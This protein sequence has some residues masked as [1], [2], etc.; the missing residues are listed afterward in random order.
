MG[1]VDPASLYRRRWKSVKLLTGYAELNKPSAH[2]QMPISQSIVLGR[3]LPGV[4]SEMV[5]FGPRQ[6]HPRR[7]L[8][9]AKICRLWMDT[10]LH[11]AAQVLNPPSRS[12]ARTLAQELDKI[13]DIHLKSMKKL[14]L[15]RVSIVGSS[16]N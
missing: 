4:H 14:S 7:T 1:A 3:A 12:I 13:C 5:D 2:P 16:P 10:I 6:G 15:W 11:F 8:H 9:R